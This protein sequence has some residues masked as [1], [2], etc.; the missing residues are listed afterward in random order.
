MRRALYLLT[1]AVAIAASIGCGSTSSNTTTGPSPAKCQ[2]T[3][4]NTTPNFSASGGS[5]AIAVEAPRECTWS[6]A[7][8]VNWV[9]L[10]PPMQ[11]QGDS[12]LKYT[13]QTN[14][15]GLPRSGS[16]NVAGQMVQVGQAGASC[17]FD[18]SPG[19]AQIAAD[20]SSIDVNVHGPTGCAWTASSEADWITI[21]QGAQGSG[22]GRVTLRALP[23]PGALRVG[24]AMIGGIRFEL[25]QLSTSGA[26]PPPPPGCTY[27]LLPTSA[28]VDAAAFDGTFSLVAGDACPWVAIS[29]QGWLSVVS[30]TSGTGNAQIAYR[31]TANDTGATRSGHI[32]VGTAAF[33]VQQAAAGEP[34]PPACTF[35]VSPKATISADAGGTTGT[36]TVNTAST[37]SWSASASQ[38]WIQLTAAAGTGTGQV[39]YDIAANTDS[40]PRTATIA[41]ADT[42]ITVTQNGAVLP[43]TSFR[44]DVSGLSGSCPA[45]TFTAD[46]R[47]VIASASTNFK[48]GNCEKLKNGDTVIVRGLLTAEGTVDATEI[49]FVK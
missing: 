25:T 32:A 19:R 24:T 5:G 13:V 44:G 38:S 11:G 28:Q 39:G 2:L 29:D 37:C 10:S 30:A 15:S 36:I 4:T 27:A 31:L 23:N 43:S 34:P 14:P 21:A 3:A 22:P 9:A 42:T 7:A 1:V 18:L 41:V 17:R 6:A 35:D 16:V 12:T 8:Q 49:E 26:P 20:A 46:G 45:V 40:T 47:T 33:T 48:G